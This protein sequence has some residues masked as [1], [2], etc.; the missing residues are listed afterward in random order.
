MHHNFFSG[1]ALQNE[2]HYFSNFTQPSCYTI[3]GF[4][5][6]A[7]KALRK[8]IEMLKEGRRVDTLVLISPAFFQKSSAKFK[9]LQRI[10]F[11]S[12]KELYLSNFIDSCFLPHERGEVELGECSARELDELLEYEWM[13]DELLFLVQ[14][15]VAIELY[16]GEKD[17]IVDA[18]A[19]KEFF[20]PYATVATVQNGNHFLRTL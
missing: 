11:A 6:G 7:I 12:N 9:K 20:L 4:S 13:E 16:L 8:T 10:A 15:G 14:R 18:A 3:S 2:L 5:Y 19:V 1:F 17:A